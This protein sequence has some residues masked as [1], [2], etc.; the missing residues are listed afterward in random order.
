MVQVAA[1]GSRSDSSIFREFG[2]DSAAPTSIPSLMLTL[3]IGLR[4]SPLLQWH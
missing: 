3:V 1:Q 4:L 2:Q